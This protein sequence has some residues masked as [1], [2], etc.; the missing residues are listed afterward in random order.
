MDVDGFGRLSEWIF[1]IMFFV[2][3]V[4]AVVGVG[5]GVLAF[6]VLRGSFVV[7]RANLA[8]C[9]CLP[10][11]ALCSPS[12]EISHGEMLQRFAHAA[13][14]FRLPAFQQLANP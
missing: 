3:T 8:A 12:M 9:D 6:F 14:C 2:D 1:V 5:V 4:V 11:F 10:V 13:N 7:A